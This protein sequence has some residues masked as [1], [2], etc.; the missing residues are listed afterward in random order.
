MQLQPLLYGPFLIA[1]SYQ[2]CKEV[3]KSQFNFFVPDKSHYRTV[4]KLNVSLVPNLIAVAAFVVTFSNLLCARLD[5]RIELS[6]FVVLIPFWLLLLYVCSYMILV[7]LAST[8][9]KV[10]KAERLLLSLFVPLGFVCSTVLA[11]CYLDG[12]LQV[13]LSFL[14][15]P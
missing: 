10:N 7:G 12:Y 5:T 11:V 2:I 3:Q 6:F 14:F 4:L 13:K 1:Y 9:S 8:N 15:I